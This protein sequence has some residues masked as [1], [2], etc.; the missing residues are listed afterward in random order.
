MMKT[1]Y[2]CPSRIRLER[3]FFEGRSQGELETHVEGC[4]S[5]RE[6]LA[7]L[8]ADR[9]AFL[10]RHPFAQ[11][12][13]RLEEKRNKAFLTKLGRWLTPSRAL[14][15]GFVLA[16]LACLMAIVV[17]RQP[18]P[19]PD[20]L[21]KGGT[22]LTFYVSSNGSSEKAQR[23]NDG[24]SLPAG[25]GVQFVYS[26]TEG[27]FLYLAGVE[28]DGAFSEYYNGPITPGSMVKLPQA[29]LWQPKSAYERFYALFSAEPISAESVRSVVAKLVQDGKSIEQAPKLP[30]SY[31]QASVLLHRKDSQ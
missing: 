12:E 19:S 6:I 3:F 25:T 5:C 21:S 4:A 1:P 26:T 8:E 28:K 27:K 29:L 22:S 13:G 24:M 9:R 18:S 2:P 16:G 14:K 11:I 23:G 15:S 17:W 31:L 30:L 20:I 10:T 7:D